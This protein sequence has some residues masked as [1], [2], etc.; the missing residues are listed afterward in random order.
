MGGNTTSTTSA[1]GSSDP[2]VTKTLD[3]LLGSGGGVS[4]LF[5]RGPKVF[6]QS[7]FAP[8][9]ATSQGAWQ[10]ALAAAH[11]P[12]YASGVQG[13]LSSQAATAAGQNVG[14]NDPTYQAM[15]A[16]NV[17]DALTSVNGSFNNSGLFGSD[18]NRKEAGTGVANAMNNLDYQQFLNGQQQQQQAIQNLPGLYSASQAPSATAG[19]I[20]TAQDTNQQG[21]LSGQADLYNRQNNSQLNLLQQL[22][23]V[24][25]GTSPSAGQT[26]TNTAPATPWW[27]SAL[28]IGA[29]LL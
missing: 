7:T 28:G 25:A 3:Q 13:A 21:I 18:T 12:T 29:S 27:Q 8:A 26:T 16:K 6:D 5:Q 11:N 23:G 2:Q 19:A 14:T 9:G 20:G 24:L 4:G 15:R 1:T 10:S 22:S 17:N